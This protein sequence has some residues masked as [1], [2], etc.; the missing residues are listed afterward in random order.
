MKRIGLALHYSRLNNLVAK[1]YVVPPL[2]VTVYTYTMKRVGQLYDV[3]GNVRNPYGLV[4]PVSRDDSIIG[5]EL[6]V[7]K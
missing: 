2:Y 3:V 1:L 7:K 5:Q 4:K 6:Y